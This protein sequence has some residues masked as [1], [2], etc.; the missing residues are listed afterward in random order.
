MN[1]PNGYSES[2]ENKKSGL[3]VAALVFGLLSIILSCCGVGVFLAPI[4]IL[5]AIIALA[6]KKN[7]KGFAITGLICGLIPTILVVTFVIAVSSILPYRNDLLNDYSRIT[8]EQDTIFAEYESTGQLPDFLQKYEEEPF[9][10]FLAKYD[11]TIYTVMDS[12][13]AAHKQG[14]LK[15]FSVS[16]SGSGTLEIPASAVL[17]SV[18][19]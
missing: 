12:L 6:T 17:I 19:A 5:L 1:E 4:A 15:T 3:S 13:M 16:G 9:K 7:G 2:T 8:Q 11:V 14:T 10:S 18:T